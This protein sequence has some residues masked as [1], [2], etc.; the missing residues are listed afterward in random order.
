[1]NAVFLFVYLFVCLSMRV[2]ILML[3]V[4]EKLR[5]STAI[6]SLIGV[7]LLISW[8]IF[9]TKLVSSFFWAN[10]SSSIIFGQ[11][12]CFFC[13]PCACYCVFLFV[14]VRLSCRQREVDRWYTPKRNVKNCPL[15]IHNMRQDLR[16]G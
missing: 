8:R 6:L 2:I 10:Q 16:D 7:E 1:M 12:L 14:R 11:S 5:S 15:Y 4:T 3:I 13:T 9:S